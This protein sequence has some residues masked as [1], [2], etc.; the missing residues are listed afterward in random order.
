MAKFCLRAF[1]YCDTE[2]KSL[3]MST[4]GVFL[5]ID[6]LSRSGGGPKRSPFLWAVFFKIDQDS[7]D[8]GKAGCLFSN[9]DHSYSMPVT[10]IS[11]GF[12]RQPAIFGIAAFLMNNGGGLTSR[13]IAA[14]QSAFNRGVQLVVDELAGKVFQKK[15]VP[16]GA[17]INRAFSDYDFNGKIPAAAKKSQNLFTNLWTRGSS[18]AGM[19]VHTW[20]QDDFGGSA[21]TKEFT[22]GIGGGWTIAGHITLADPCPVST[23]A[24]LLDPYYHVT[25]VAEKKRRPLVPSLAFLLDLLQEF[26]GKKSI[27]KDIRLEDWWRLAKLHTPELAYRLTVHKEAR[28][29]LLVLTQHL[30]THL[31]DDDRRIN[32]ETIRHIDYFLGLLSDHVSRRFKQDIEQTLATIPHL[33]NKTLTQAVRIMAASVRARKQEAILS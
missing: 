5:S 1:S 14:G 20:S 29:G 21:E 17:D 9:G 7:L 19:V 3:V 24:A 22:L 31:Q 2:V 28:D 26:K 18:E 4:Q 15:E 32:R 8:S 27:L 16:D 33:Y 25:P 13:G 11:T 10:T 30:V 23:S 12:V 6:S